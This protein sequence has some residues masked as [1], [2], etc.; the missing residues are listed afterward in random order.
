LVLKREQWFHDQRAYPFKHIPAGAFQKALEQRDKMRQQQ[1]SG[2]GLAN[3]IIGFPGDG[4]W[5]AIGPQPTDVPALLGQFPSVNNFGFPTVSGRVTALAADPSDTTGQTVYLGGAAGG[6]WKTTNGGTSWTALT[7][8]QPSLAVGSI[9]IDPNSCS[10]GPCT[11]IYVGTGEENFNQDAYFGAGILKSTNGGTSWTQLGAAQFAGAQSPS[12]GAKIGA[13]AAQWEEFIVR[14]TGARLGPRLRPARL[15]QRPRPLCLS[16]LPTRGQAQLYM[17]Q[18]GIHLATLRT[19]S[20]S[21]RIP[22]KRGH[23]YLAACQ[24][25]MLGASPWPTRHLLPAPAQLCMPRL[26]T[27]RPAPV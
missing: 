18:W 27:L 1:Q 11:T 21:P 14:Q 2:L 9:A 12:G 5:H 20:I 15:A 8:T 3:P 19:E 16:Q 13:M 6:V 22:A 26:R 4:V 25:P 10:P 17:Q 7:D 24:Q 23:S